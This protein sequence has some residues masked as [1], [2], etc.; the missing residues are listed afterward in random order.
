MGERGAGGGAA[1]TGDT[2]GVV[3]R[4]D[5]LAPY[6]APSVYSSGGGMG[7]GGGGRGGG[8]RGGTQEGKE[9][10]RDPLTPYPT[11]PPY[12]P[13]N[14]VRA[15]ALANNFANSAKPA[16]N[17]ARG[18]S[19]GGFLPSQVATHQSGVGGG[20]GKGFLKGLVANVAD[21]LLV[22]KRCACA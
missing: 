21:S 9:G 10:R 8:G 17:S 16:N 3:R 15:R 13:S 14:A 12:S 22:S 1:V 18:P 20:G 11:P 2:P 4:R 5:P 19:Q 7:R 6:P